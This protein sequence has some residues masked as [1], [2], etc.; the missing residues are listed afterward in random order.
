[1]LIGAK[2]FAHS[3][4]HINHLHSLAGIAGILGIGV[5][6]SIVSARK[7]HAKA[8]DEEPVDPAQPEN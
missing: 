1:M 4:I 3:W 6:A 2:M 7:E 8:K 5:I